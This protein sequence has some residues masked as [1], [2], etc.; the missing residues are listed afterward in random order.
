MQIQTT[1][2]TGVIPL[3]VPTAQHRAEPAQ[4]A[5]SLLVKEK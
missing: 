2:G 1:Y 3:H 5:Y 4:L